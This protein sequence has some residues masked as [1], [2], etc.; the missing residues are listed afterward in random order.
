MEM[1]RENL[2]VCDY[3]IMDIERNEGLKA[4]LR[5]YVDEYDDVESKCDWCGGVGFDVLYELV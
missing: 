3:C 2:W 4:T 5:H 1:E